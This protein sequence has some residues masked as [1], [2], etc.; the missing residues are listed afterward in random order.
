MGVGRLP[1]WVILINKS[2]SSFQN[3]V[4]RAKWSRTEGSRRRRRRRRRR[5]IR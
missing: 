5:R 2:A 3:R 4:K 1:F